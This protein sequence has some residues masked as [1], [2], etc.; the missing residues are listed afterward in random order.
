[1]FKRALTAACIALF[2]G[3]SLADTISAGTT[4]YVGSTVYSNDRTHVLVMQGDGNLVLYRSGTSQAPW[5]SATTGRGGVRAIMQSDG[6]FVIYD[7]ANRAVWS[8]NTAG[9]PGSYASVENT[10]KFVIYQPSIIWTGVGGGNTGGG[11]Q[12]DPEDPPCPR[13]TPRCVPR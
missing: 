6:N 11:G 10:G 9:R 13:L 8:S 12:P 3:A 4:L 7:G 5:S 2:S 1:M